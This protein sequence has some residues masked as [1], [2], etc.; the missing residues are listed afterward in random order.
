[1]ADWKVHSPHTGSLP[2]LSA[3]G[4]LPQGNGSPKD[5]ALFIRQLKTP[6]FYMKSPTFKMLIIF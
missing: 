2:L 3:G 5:C 6:E 4:T 1:M